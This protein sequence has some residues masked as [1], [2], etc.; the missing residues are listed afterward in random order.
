MQNKVCIQNLKF[1]SIQFNSI[2]NTILYNACIFYKIFYKIN[3]LIK[4]I[5]SNSLIQISSSSVRVKVRCRHFSA[6]T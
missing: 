1:N 3:L 5:Y 2:P 4:C 6:F